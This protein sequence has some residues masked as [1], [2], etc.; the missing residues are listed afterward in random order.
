MPGCANCGCGL[1]E[2][3]EHAFYYCE[4]FRPFWDHFGELTARIEPKQLVL[5]AI[6]YVLDN[7][8]PPFKAETRVMFLVIPA[9]ARMVIWT[10]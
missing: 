1:E 7:V 10:T 5:L 6:G 9:V 4:R 8:L 3:T 2:T